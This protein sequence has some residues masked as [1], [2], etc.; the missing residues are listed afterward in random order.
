MTV[1]SCM[2]RCALLA[3]GLAFTPL[4]QAQSCV[5]PTT[6]ATARHGT[7][8][9]W[10]ADPAQAY[11]VAKKTRRLVFEMHLSGEFASPSLT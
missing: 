9:D 3:L 1:S 6:S 11:A 7:K 10:Y 2:T 8:V 4:A 5:A